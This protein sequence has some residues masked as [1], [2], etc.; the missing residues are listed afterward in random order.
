MSGLA[1]DDNALARNAYDEVE[2]AGHFLGCSHTLQ[3]YETAYYETTLSDND[4]LEQWQE[5]GGKDS[6]QRA[7]DHWQQL[8]KEYEQP[9]IDAARDEALRDFIERRKREIPEQWY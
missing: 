3:N 2:P 8:L 6:A 9:A 7:F 1:T 4:N 5:K